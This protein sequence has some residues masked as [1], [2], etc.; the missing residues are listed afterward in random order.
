VF[1]KSFLFHGCI[2]SLFC[3]FPTPFGYAPLSIC[4]SSA[5]EWYSFNLNFIKHLCIWSFI[6]LDITLILLLYFTLNEHKI[7][8]NFPFIVFFL[9]KKLYN[10]I[11]QLHCF[12]CFIL[13]QVIFSHQ[14]FD[15][16]NILSLVS[17]VVWIYFL[18]YIDWPFA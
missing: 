9:L 1:I 2:I 3:Y 18:Y 5:S 16:G 8:L 7:A 14:K 17:T 13:L 15:D 10:F 11:Q 4:N 12:I 6:V